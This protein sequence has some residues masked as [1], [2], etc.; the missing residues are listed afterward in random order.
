[1]G[2]FRVSARL[3]I[4]TLVVLAIIAAGTAAG[5][6][7]VANSQDQSQQNPAI[8]AAIAA[9]A[10]IRH[11][12]SLSAT[13]SAVA[14]AGVSPEALAEAGSSID[15]DIA[16]VRGQLD[17]LA[18]AGYEQA[19]RRMGELVDRLTHTTAQ[20]DELWPQLSQALSDSQR[21]RQELVDLVTW[22]LL[23]AAQA[24][25]DDTFY[26][27]MTGRSSTAPGTTERIDAVSPEDTLRYARLALLPQQIEQAFIALEVSTRQNDK[28]YIG[29][30]EENA[31]LALNPLEDS[32]DSFSEAAPPE[33]DPTLIPLVRELI[34]DAHGES[35]MID[36]LK[37]RAGLVEQEA[38]LV[39]VA[40][41][42]LASL[43]ADAGTL[44]DEIIGSI[45]LADAHR[46]TAAALRAAAAVAQSAEA[47]T[48][49]SAVSTAANT[50]PAEL[51]ATH[52][53]VAANLATAR[54]QL[55]SLDSSG[56]GETATV[57]R[58]KLDRL[59]SAVELVHSGRRELLNAL[60]VT[61]TEAAGSL[62]TQLRAFLDYQL[63]PAVQTSMD[64]QL[65]WMLT[66]RSE[67]GDTALGE[68][69]P[70]SPDE[71][72]RY[73]HLNVA[74]NS[75]FRILSGLIKAIAFTDPTLI[76]AAE[77]DFA[78]AAHRLDKSIE[79]LEQNEGAQ[80]VPQ[81]VPLARQYIAF[82]QGESN[83]FDSL[84]QRLPLVA[85][86]A[87]QIKAIQQINMA[88]QADADALL[89]EILQDAV[90]ADLDTD[91][92]NA[93]AIVLILGIVAA[94]VTLLIA[95]WSARR[96]AAQ[97]A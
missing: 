83:V 64:N 68:S 51:A 81:L 5:S 72:L 87:E 7:A 4:I 33:L 30:I 49:A 80:V 22:R 44:L 2:R 8:R 93:R 17:V 94:A 15:A 3:A 57:M 97:S 69:D 20:L 56:Y 82:G 21:R 52:E 38:E 47:A 59:E 62:R 24:S 6:V 88:L 14:G 28:R 75:L 16:A 45:G 27:M 13:V 37:T 34:E 18:D 55:E 63:R 77:E 78:V 65:Y 40:K 66:A 41:G 58:S 90:S 53:A 74:F 1:M 48:A 76:S 84:R 50:A 19:S 43:Q 89:D 46:H 10:V 67:F 60:Q 32:I 92:S 39:A 29:V 54:G 9:L 71:L 70:L 96:N 79:Y 86:E 25:E 42:V 85:A 73:R 11:T 12:D 35:N 61:A 36:L 95:A 23:P 91:D 26:R 31:S